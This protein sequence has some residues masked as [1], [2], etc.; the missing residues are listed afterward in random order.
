[1]T[2]LRMAEYFMI[3]CLDLQSRCH[4]GPNDSASHIAEKVMR[5]LNECLGDGRSIPV[6]FSPLCDDQGRIP[7]KEVSI[8]E[9]K[10]LKAEKDRA[11]AKECARMIKNRFD[12]KSSMGSS[13]HANTPCYENHLQFFF[14]EE[15]LVKCA[16][17]TT[18]TALEKCAGKEYYKF[19]R[20]FF[21][22]H[23]FV[24][25]NGFEGFRNGCQTAKNGQIC[26]YHSNYEN[27]FLL[28]NGFCGVPVT[29]V[30]PPVPDYSFTGE[31]FHYAPPHKISSGDIT[32][33][34]GLNKDSVRDPVTREIDQFCPR[35]HLNHFV[36]SFGR[37]ELE[38]TGIGQP[39]ECATDKNDILGKILSKVDDFVQ[40][41]TGEDLKVSVVEEIKRRHNSMI[42]AF[43]A[44]QTHANT[45]AAEKARTCDDFDWGKLVCTNE[46]SSLY[47]SQ[48]N[49][50]LIKNLNLTKT[51]YERTG[52]T[53][54]KKIEEIKKHY[55]AFTAT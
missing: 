3:N 48:L 4:Y 36:E 50:Y 53:K 47:V 22:D 30:Q 29:R 44:K 23:Y 52:F 39:D 17:A 18:E 1:M 35:A 34:F 8:E 2:Q 15:F 21:Q 37:P 10:K 31:E 43:I 25:D 46:L 24:F 42:K 26:E 27:P 38:M 12:G 45:R 49:L 40:K 20:D 32:E 14:D 5:S 41:F 54:A 13:I 28:S 51:Q 33:K 6:P 16:S 9:L 11:T 7:L 55:Y 19:V